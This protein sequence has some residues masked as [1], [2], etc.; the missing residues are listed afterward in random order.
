VCEVNDERDFPVA[1][2]RSGLI[3]AR[4]TAVRVTLSFTARLGLV[5]NRYKNCPQFVE[6]M[7]KYF[8]TQ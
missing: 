6:K 3:N 2:C 8:G 7:G 4:S 1:I 5:R